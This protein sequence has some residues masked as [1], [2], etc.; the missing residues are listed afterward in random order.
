MMKKSKHHS[1]AKPNDSLIS[2]GTQVEGSLMVP[3]NL[4]IDGSFH[5]EITCEG[6]IVI[7]DQG[8]VHAKLTA[9]DV[10]ISGEMNGE[11]KCE[12]KLTITSTGM[13]N[14]NCESQWLVIQE[15][16]RLNGNSLTER[17]EQPSRQAPQ[18]STAAEH[19][20]NTHREKQAG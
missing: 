13:L 4:R 12:G 8:E 20:A 16:G 19:E 1:K 15:G 7:G 6:T 2:Y 18:S 11:I 9:R 17:K 10:I 5:G 3:S 14:G